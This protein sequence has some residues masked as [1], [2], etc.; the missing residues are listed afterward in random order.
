MDHAP[1]ATSHVFCIDA[2]YLGAGKEK[3]GTY[4]CS[5]RPVT[6]WENPK[7]VLGKFQGYVH[8]HPNFHSFYQDPAMGWPDVHTRVAP[9]VSVSVSGV[10]WR[11]LT[12]HTLPERSHKRGLAS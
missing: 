1:R 2:S 5:I 8:D 9:R 12:L 6:I 4:Q 11:H 3:Q 10:S 7:T